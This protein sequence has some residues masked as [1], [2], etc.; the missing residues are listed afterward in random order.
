MV[1]SL[2]HHIPLP[3]VCRSEG[4]ERECVCHQANQKG[5]F[6]VQVLGIIFEGWEQGPLLRPSY[7]PKRLLC[8]IFCR[9]F[10]MAQTQI[11]KI[12]KKHTKTMSPYSQAFT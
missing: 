10:F 9:I 11:Y 7:I 3:Q 1:Q 4:E 12:M 8:I 6:G 2:W 5:W